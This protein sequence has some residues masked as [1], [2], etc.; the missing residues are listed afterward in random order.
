MIKNRGGA[1]SNKGCSETQEEPED[2]KGIT[3]LC[4]ILADVFG[5]GAYV[6]TERTGIAGLTGALAKELARNV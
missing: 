6:V 1:Q 3:N 4:E 5:G 2:R